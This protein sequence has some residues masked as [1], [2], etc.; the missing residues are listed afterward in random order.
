MSTAL[1]LVQDVKITEK[2]QLQVTCEVEKRQLV[3]YDALA[4][5]LDGVKSI[6]EN[7]RTPIWGDQPCAKQSCHPE[8]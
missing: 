4:A 6:Q 8:R 2:Q 3:E 7:V 1:G 5:Q